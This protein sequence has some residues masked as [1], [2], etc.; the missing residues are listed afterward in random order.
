MLLGFYLYCTVCTEM[1][2]ADCKKR[3]IEPVKDGQAHAAKNACRKI[4]GK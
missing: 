3:A 4:V 2:A 1:L